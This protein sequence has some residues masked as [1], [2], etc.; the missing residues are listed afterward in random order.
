MR[1]P[2]LRLPPV[3]GNGSRVGR[4]DSDERLDYDRANDYQH[5]TTDKHGQQGGIRSGSG[6]GGTAYPLASFAVISHFHLHWMQP[7]CREHG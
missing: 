3:L 2:P 6:V 4:T 5:E 1:S 7:A